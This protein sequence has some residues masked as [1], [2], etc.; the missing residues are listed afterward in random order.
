MGSTLLTIGTLLG[1]LGLF[2]LAVRMIT[3]GLRMAAGSALRE[4]L[5]IWTST[6]LR[7]I[8]AGVLITALVQSS[9]AVTAATIGFVNAGLLSLSHSLGV[10]YGAN[11]GTTMT[12]W[13]VAAVGFKIKLELFALPILGVGVAMRLFGANKRMGA[14]GEAIAGFGLFFLGVQVLKEAFE[15]LA[16]N[17]QFSDMSTDGFFA[18]AMFLLIGFIMTLLTQSSSAAIAITL[19]AA[20]GGVIPIAPAAAIVIGANLGTTSTAAI[21]VIGATSNAKRVALAHVLFN[22]LT[23]GVAL[24]L[25][26]VLLWTVDVTGKVLS[27]EDS[28]AVALALFHTV[29][30]ILG[31]LLM[32]PLT[33]YLSRFLKQRFRSQEEIAARPKYLDKT[34]AVSPELAV[35]A[36]MLEVARIGRKANESALNALSR[37]ITSNAPMRQSRKTVVNLSNE[38]GNFAAQLERGNL[39]EEIVRTIPNVLRTARYFVSLSDLAAEV[40]AETPQLSRQLPDGLNEQHGAF[41]AA[42]SDLLKD[43]TPEEAPLETQQLDD[44][45]QKLKQQYQELKVAYLTTG[46]NGQIPIVDMAEHLEY[47]SRTRRMAEQSVKGKQYLNALFRPRRENSVEETTAMEDEI[48]HTH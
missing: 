32:W 42:V 7:G 13:L 43:H 11:I 33:K 30:N 39:S 9:S 28:P 20:T 44:E 38:L 8:A 12:G 26:P 36:M 40:G 10:V 45:I 47:I 4:L 17:I 22:A 15:G 5:G 3:D 27:L 24:I 21:A 14:I 16:A 37:D 6:P 2:L 29:F 31:V 34:V 46:A 25:L 23:G 35:D 18:T 48:E 41:I 1:G 19:T